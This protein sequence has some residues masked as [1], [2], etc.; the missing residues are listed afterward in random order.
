MKTKNLAVPELATVEIQGVT[1]GA[2]LARGA[3]AAGAAYGL[4]AVSPF[5]SNAL[6]ASGDV[7]I[8]NF[9]LTLE[10][11]EAAFYTEAAK[12]VP[13]MSGDL[14]AL[15]K[16]IRDNETEHVDALTAAVKQLGGKPAAVPGVDFGGA[17][18]SKD[19]FLKLA[20][21]FEDTGVSA[22]NGA[23][24]QI[25]SQQ[26]LGAA[27]SI[28]QVEARHSALIRLQRDQ[29]PAP[30]AFDKS[31]KTDEVLAAVKPFIKG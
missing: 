31:L 5:V 14:K 17:F 11:L 19:T 30:Y 15:V 1:R 25:T 21:T 13:G 29:T 9:A 7:D 20:Q 10:Y 27:G 18:G 12:R 23:A 2:F 16:E 26:I 6:A 3:M 4:G 22:Y 28:V 24:P 8:V